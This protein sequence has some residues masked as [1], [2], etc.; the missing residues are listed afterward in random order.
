MEAKRE[1]TIKNKAKKILIVDD[2]PSILE[3][4]STMLT[5]LGYKVFTAI[6]GK[7]GLDMIGKILPDLVLL[8]VV[9]PVADGFDVLKEIKNDPVLARIPVILL[10]N[11]A[12]KEDKDEGYKLG[13]SDYLMKVQYSPS[14]LAEKVKKFLV[15]KEK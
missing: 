13:A 10:T 6:N 2:E 9:M 4:Y 11:L 3:V 7:K 1:G 15:A 14:R 8:D 12:N 5:Q